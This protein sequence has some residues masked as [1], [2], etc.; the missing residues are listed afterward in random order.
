[1]RAALRAPPPPPS[2]GAPH[3]SLASARERVRAAGRG[4]RQ[5]RDGALSAISSYTAEN[6]SLQLMRGTL[7]AISAL[8]I[9]AFFTVHLDGDK[10]LVKKFC[11]LRIFIILFL[12]FFT[13]K[14]GGVANGQIDQL[15]L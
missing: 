13:S 3:A 2:G 1:M 10:V 11:H 8:V 15:V 6:S 9:G 4:P 14:A 5:V 7:F 12:H